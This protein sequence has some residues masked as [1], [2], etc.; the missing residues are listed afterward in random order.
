M[1]LIA[2]KTDYVNGKLVFEEILDKETYEKQLFD[3][4]DYEH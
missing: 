1:M 2:G 4:F 3:D